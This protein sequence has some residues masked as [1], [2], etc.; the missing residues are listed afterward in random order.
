MMDPLPIQEE[1]TAKVG[2]R[3]FGMLTT[4]GASAEYLAMPEK[5]A[6]AQIPASLSFE[7]DEA[8]PLNGWLRRAAR[9]L[10]ERRCQ[11]CHRF[12]SDP[13]MHTAVNHQAIPNGND[14][15]AANARR[16]HHPP[17]K[18]RIGGLHFS[19]RCGPLSASSRAR[20]SKSA[21]CPGGMSPLTVTATNP[22]TVGDTVSRTPGLSITIPFS[23][24]K[25]R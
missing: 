2:D 10:I 16:S 14:Q 9:P 22:L 4:G 1:L 5:G 24:P 21:A 17:Q 19:T 3:V 25:S 23:A 15:S 7:F 20:R 6:I 8:F 13:H 11:R 12:T 18:V